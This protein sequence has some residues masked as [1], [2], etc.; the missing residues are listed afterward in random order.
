[1]TDPTVRRFAALVLLAI[2][3]IT[4]VRAM[5]AAGI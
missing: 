4:G 5:G 3:V 2:I 1:M